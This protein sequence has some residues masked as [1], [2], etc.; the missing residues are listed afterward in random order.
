MKI[1]F[2][3]EQAA[4][5]P[6]AHA[7]YSSVLQYHSNLQLFMKTYV[8]NEWDIKGTPSATVGTC[9]HKYAELRLSGSDEL[10]ALAESN[11]LFDSMVNDAER[12]IDW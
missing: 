5:L 4:G 11:L 3:R 1:P 2:T 12:P 6:I 7:S 10:T 8:R 9:A